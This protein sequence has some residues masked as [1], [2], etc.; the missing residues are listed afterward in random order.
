MTDIIDL[1]T[2]FTTR[3]TP[4]MVEA[5]ARAAADWPGFG[6]RDDPH[7]AKLERAA[8]EIL[9]KEDALFCPTCAAANQIAINV[10]CRPGDALVAE[11]TSHILTSEAGA[12]GALSGL[13]VRALTGVRGQVPLEAMA[14]AMDDGDDVQPR[15]RL[16][17]IE[18][19]HVRS[20]GCVLSSEYMASVRN[21]AQDRGIPVHLD[22]SRLFNAAAALGARACQIA[23]FAD[24]VSVSLNKGLA[25]PL[26]AIL[27]GPR[28]VISEAMRVR[29]RL[30]GSWRPA[31]IPAAAALVALITMVSRLGEDHARA[32]ELAEGLINIP[33]L[34][35]DP[36]QVQTNI[37]LVDLE[38]EIGNSHSVAR[39]LEKSGVLVLPFGP[40]RLR[41]VTSYEVGHA[42]VARTVD[43]FASLGERGNA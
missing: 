38:P 7:V 31:S 19:T 41:L 9:G 28:S 23:S 22:G 40:Q 33:G 26:G 11:A 1:R 8:A 4:A 34:K 42:E 25:A 13:T 27:A 43:A 12:V 17:V 20:G 29:H 24:T 36:D 3:P 6:L 18:N 37:V 30:G 14:A 15:T 35:I 21:A 16:V 10:F 39:R 5:M 32:R 2:D